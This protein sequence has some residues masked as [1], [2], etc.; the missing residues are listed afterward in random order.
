MAT[1]LSRVIYGSQVL[2]SLPN[3]LADYGVKRHVFILTGRSLAFK[4]PVIESIQAILNPIQTTVFPDISQHAPVE[5]IKRAAELMARSQ[6]EAVVAVGGGSPIDSGKLVLKEYFDAFGVWLPYIAIPT[7]LSA[8]ECTTTAGMT[9]PEGH[10]TGAALKD[11]E[12]VPKVI[13]YDGETAMHTPKDL[14]VS[15]GMRA[16]DHA[17]ELQYLEGAPEFQKQL[18]LTAV[19]DLVEILPL[20]QREEGSETDQRNLR[21]QALLAAFRSLFP[22]ISLRSIGMSH[23]FGHALG[24][25][26]GIP[27]GITSCLTLPTVLRYKASK[28]AE[29]AKAIAKIARYLPGRVVT[30]SKSDVEV[31][32]AVADAVQA[33]VEELGY[34][35]TLDDYKVPRSRQEAESIVQRAR[36][37]DREKDPLKHEE[38]VKLVYSLY[39][40]ESSAL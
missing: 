35:K 9:S 7:T 6:P 18:A 38:L 23:S 13:I 36:L 22:V 39:R 31:A 5:A 2:Q 27:H 11:S 30:D 34:A 10:K 28:S 37:V 40:S 3:V 19:S 29:E 32:N 14:F 24:A 15:S 17:V 21:V 26:Y 4:T 25:S 1:K 16:V 20:I 12:W 8:A 33:L